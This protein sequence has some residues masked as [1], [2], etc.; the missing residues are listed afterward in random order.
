MDLVS[1]IID[2]LN[3]IMVPTCNQVEH[4]RILGERMEVLRSKVEELKCKKE[5]IERKIQT[6]MCS[7]KEVSKE[8]EHWL[9]YVDK[10]IE[11]IQKV[12]DKFQNVSFL[13]RSC[14][15]KRVQKKI[16]ELDKI[17]EKASWRTLRDRAGS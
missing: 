13:C 14:L 9:K 10:F 8:V 15:S 1:P 16:E 3:C 12:E 4:H 2:L 11:G 5:D 6:E 17:L 7:D